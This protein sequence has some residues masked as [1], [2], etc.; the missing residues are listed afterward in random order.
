[1]WAQASRTIAIG[2]P[3]VLPNAVTVVVE[4]GKVGL[5][6]SAMA[7]GVVAAVRRGLLVLSRC[8]VVAHNCA[9]KPI[10]IVRVH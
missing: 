9:V 2:N 8:A 7:R 6:A 5:V 10:G 3:R 4:G 1:M